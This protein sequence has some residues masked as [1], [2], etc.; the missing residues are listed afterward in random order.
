MVRSLLL[1]LVFVV[2]WV[3]FVQSQTIY[4][5]ISAG[6]IEEARDSL[7]RQSSA[8]VRDATTLFCQALLE[9]EAENAVRLMDAALAGRPLAEHQEEIAFRLAQFYLMRKDYR[10]VAEAVTDYQSRW[11]R[12]RFRGEMQRLS[13]LAD[14]QGKAYA[15]ALKQC[16]AYLMD[17]SAGD[18]QHWGLVDKVRILMAHGKDIGAGE[19]LRQ[20]SKA[21]KGVG[22]VV[23][24]AAS[25]V[26]ATHCRTL[27]I[28]SAVGE[29]ARANCGSSSLARSAGKAEKTIFALIDSGAAGATTMLRA[30]SGMGLLSTQR[31]ACAYGS[32]I[33]RSDAA[34]VTTLNHGW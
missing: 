8:S 17:N 24:D 29:T 6:R 21:K 27:A 22:A 1:T 3:A 32:P 30:Y 31:Q 7:G 14:E 10:K 11:E 13:I 34:R 26:A 28:S 16:D 5:L 23:S 19:T 9:P 15:S 20:L 4:E 12:G 2:C 25:N 33:E 18:R